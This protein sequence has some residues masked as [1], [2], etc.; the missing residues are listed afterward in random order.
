M[1]VDTHIHLAD[2]EYL[3]ILDQVIEEAKGR[4]K[5]II[6]SGI[7]YQTSLDAIRLAE[8]YDFLYASIGLH[9]RRK[10]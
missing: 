4:F 2:K 1:L 9:S 7:D 3:E 5:S 8:K 10:D 6:V